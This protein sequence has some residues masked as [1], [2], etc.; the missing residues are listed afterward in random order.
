MNKHSKKL[1]PTFTDPLGSTAN[2]KAKKLISDFDLWHQF[3]FGDESAFV[4]IYKLFG[5]Q[6]YNY[7]CQFS[8]DKELVKDCLQDF[9]IYLRKN[10]GKF[11]HTDS[12]KFYLM[13][14]FKRYILRILKRYS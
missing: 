10:R 2:I 3:Q 12:I 7:G 1:R 4:E 11:S 9:F 5:N 6:L 8:A 13:K 14:S